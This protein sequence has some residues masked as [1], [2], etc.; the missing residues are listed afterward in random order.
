MDP[1]AVVDTPVF[2]DVN[3]NITVVWNPEYIPRGE[4]S[5]PGNFWHQ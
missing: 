3:D 5:L 2:D 1:K 4:V